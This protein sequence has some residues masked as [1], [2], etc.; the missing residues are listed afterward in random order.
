MAALRTV[1]ADADPLARRLIKSILRDAGVTVIAEA[2]DRRET[3]ELVCHYRPDV[4]VIDAGGPALDG[5]HA[6]RAIHARHPSQPVVVLACAD[7]ERTAL[8]ALQ[9]GAS[10]FI[11][12]EA[13]VDALPRA[14]AR[15]LEGEAAI[16]GRLARRLIERIR[17]PPAGTGG[18]RPIRGPLTAREWE[19]VDLLGHST[20]DIAAALVI[21]T[22]TV[23]SH[24]KS[25]MRKLGVHTRGEALAAAER[26]RLASA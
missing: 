12:K 20:D 24:V 10:G 3:I 8:L 11:S 7:D 6:T 18:L 19:I 25:I 5:I 14:L 16:S 22:E 9:A 13:D 21:S 15:V 2:R 4:A 1:V 23:R 26:L 17:H